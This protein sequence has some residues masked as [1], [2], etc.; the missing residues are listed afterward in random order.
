MVSLM[1][2]IGSWMGVPPWVT[3][4]TAQGRPSFL[5]GTSM[6]SNISPCASTRTA[7]SSNICA[8]RRWRRWRR[9]GS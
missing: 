4:F 3:F 7:I 5:G 9:A 6:A 2:L 8:W 1:V